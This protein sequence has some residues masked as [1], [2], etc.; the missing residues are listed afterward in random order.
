MG[1]IQL[2][3]ILFFGGGGFYLGPPYHCLRR[4]PRRDI[5]DRY[6]SASIEGVTR[7]LARYVRPPHVWMAPDLQEFSS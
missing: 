3:I 5:G 6:H 7:P 2:L 4:R 1:L